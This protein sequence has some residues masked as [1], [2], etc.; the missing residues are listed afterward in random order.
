VID[1]EI[2]LKTR[3]RGLSASAVVESRTWRRP[4]R[5]RSSAY[6]PN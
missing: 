1:Q 5:S 4:I 2:R 3:R 6:R